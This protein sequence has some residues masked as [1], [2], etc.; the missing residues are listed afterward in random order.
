MTL[1]QY[2]LITNYY[3]SG[4]KFLLNEAGNSDMEI[5]TAYSALEIFKTLNNLKHVTDSNGI[6]THNHLV[7]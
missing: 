1:D 4:Y 5:N 2:G 3:N 6:P 7:R